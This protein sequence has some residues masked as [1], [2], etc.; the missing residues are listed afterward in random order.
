VAVLGAVAVGVF[1]AALDRRL[2]ALPVPAGVRQAVLAQTPKLAEAA[3]PAAIGGEAQAE[4]SRALQESFVSSF[5][6][7]LLIAAALALASAACAWLTI[8]A[9]R[10][11]SPHEGP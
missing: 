8:G 4:L 9:G 2:D 5:R 7:V 3:V 11:R 10:L 6:V 1:R